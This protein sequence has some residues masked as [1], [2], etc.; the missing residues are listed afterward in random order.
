M[1][2]HIG[3]VTKTERDGSARIIADRKG[4]CGGCDHRGGGCRSCL[5]GAN[6]IESAAANPIG[7]EVGDLV[8]VELSSGNLFA[9]AALLYLLPVLG[10]LTGAF[11]GEFLADWA[12]VSRLA[13]AIFGAVS[14]LVLGYGALLVMD[15]DQRLRRRWLPTITQVVQ[16]GIGLPATAL[17]TKKR[18]SCCS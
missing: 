3:I 17:P 16:S 18:A 6:R 7:A 10:L 12:N 5:S 8:K 15:R 1:A 11:T 14:G 4:A 9:G 2:E 13:G